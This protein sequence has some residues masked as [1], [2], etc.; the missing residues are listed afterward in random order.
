MAMAVF[1]G[2]ENANNAWLNY[3]ADYYDGE[4]GIAL[5]DTFGSI[6]F[7]ENFNGKLTRLW[8]GLRQDS[9]DP[10]KWMDTKVIPH[11]TKHNVPTR[12]KKIVFSDN[13]NVEKAIKLHLKYDGLFNVIFGIGTFLTNDTFTDEQKVA[14]IK[15]LN[16]VV[17]LTSANFGRGWRPT[18]KLSDDT[19]KICGSSLLADHVKKQLNIS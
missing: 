17:K 9:G 2:Y 4:L 6:A 1:V 5:P 10:E 18:L 11:Y 13:L 15:P 7:F 8:D 12:D 19:G 3:W 14:G 16:I